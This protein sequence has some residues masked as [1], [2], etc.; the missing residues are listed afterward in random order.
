MIYYFFISNFPG[1]ILQNTFS[2]SSLRMAKLLRLAIPKSAKTRIYYFFHNKI[3]LFWIKLESRWFNGIL[4]IFCKD[5]F[6]SFLYL[7][8]I[9]DILPFVRYVLYK[10]IN[11][12]QIDP[13]NLINLLGLLRQIVLS[14]RY[15]FEKITTNLIS[16]RILVTMIR[17]KV[18]ERSK[19]L[20]K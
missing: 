2:H 19:H 1:K 12:I 17:W 7:K 3:E 14:L 5:F 9:V 6:A 8:Q 16:N 10:K 13:Y 4:W 20:L 18:L 15:P 11:G